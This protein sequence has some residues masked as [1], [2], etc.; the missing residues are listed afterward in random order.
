[1]A[2]LPYWRFLRAG[3]VLAR[4]GVFAIVPLDDAPASAKFAI[5][6]IRIIERPS[7]RRRDMAARLSQAFDRL[8][9]SYI[10][11]GQFLATRADVVGEE[12]AGELA[13]LQDQVPPVPDEAARAA[14]E[15]GL[16]APIDTIFSEF[17][18]CIA[19]ASIAQVYRAKLTDVRGERE[20]AVK[21]LRP[22]VARRFEKD[23]EAYYTAAR[24]VERFMPSARRLRPVAVV[25]TLAASVRFEMDLRLEAA[26]MS[27]M[28]ENIVEDELF[29]VPRVEWAR[30]A[31]T[32][33]TME[34][35]D[36][37]KLSRV[38]ELREA[39]HD[40]PDLGRNVL[41]TFLRHAV[42]DGFF[43]ADMHQGNLFAEA[44]GT[45][46]AVDLGITGRL[47]REERGF[48]AEILYGFIERDYHR[49]AEVHFRAGYVP[50]TQDVDLF[51]QALRAVGEP[52]RDATAAELS[53]SRLL[54]Q[55][56][57]TTELFQMTTQPQLIMLQKTMVVVEGVAR[58]LDPQLNIWHTAEPVVRDW[59]VAE[60]GPGATVRKAQDSFSA[61]TRAALAAPQLAERMERLSK[62]FEVALEK[63]LPISDRSIEELGRYA[64]ARSFVR[65]GALWLGAVSLAVLA[66]NSF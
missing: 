59:M 66:W 10:K 17:G 60:L 9:P 11:L 58:S 49:V 61:I 63:G 3:F 57:E 13:L 56:F 18:E 12:V 45:L 5:R 4:E 46:V 54:A 62:D 15:S 34:W 48:L 6:L 31:R 26:A 7:A 32:V 19:A 35:I 27:E 53:M 37:I 24:F 64:F 29:R 8:G 52:I 51:A 25:D 38:G 47:T 55:L 42:R 36:G 14:I 23:L 28:A 21:V 65:V 50:M 30:T 44:D 41:Q 40:L 39:G 33:L 16:G 43:H 22:G 20:V 2:L 1:M